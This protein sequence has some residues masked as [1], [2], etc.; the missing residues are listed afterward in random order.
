MIF[1][2]SERVQRFQR[3]CQRVALVVGAGMLV[4][5][6]SCAEPKITKEQ[7]E[8]IR[9][10]RKQQSA[11]NDKI[12]SSQTEIAR[13]EAE[14]AD[15]QKAVDKC[16]EEKAAVQER[17]DKWPNSWPD[18]TPPPAVDTTEAKKAGKKGK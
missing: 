4:I 16:N 1:Q 8:Q 2:R 15:R 14:I 11:L 17:L 7:L 5:L 12:R 13:I 10:L 18:Y 9:E 3:L 6:A